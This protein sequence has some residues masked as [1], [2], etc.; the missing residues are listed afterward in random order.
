MSVPACS[1]KLTEAEKGLKNN[2]WRVNIFKWVFFT[3]LDASSNGALQNHAYLIQLSIL[4]TK[5]G[6]EYVVRALIQSTSG[7]RQ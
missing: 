1:R 6:T 5:M 3:K 7:F 2:L 4:A